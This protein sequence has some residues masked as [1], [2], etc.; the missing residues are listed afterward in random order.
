MCVSVGETDWKMLAIDVSDPLADQM[1]GRWC[2][3]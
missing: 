3:Y 2:V 1:S